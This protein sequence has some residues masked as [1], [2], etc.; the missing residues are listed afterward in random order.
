MASKKMIALAVTSSL[1]SAIAA[2]VPF[3][4]AAGTPVITLDNVDANPGTQV[5]V[6]VYLEENEGING[7]SFSVMY[8][9]SA[10]TLLEVNEGDYPVTNIPMED[11]SF[12]FGHYSESA[13]TEEEVLL[14]EMVFDVNENAE[15]G[16]YFL[17]INYSDVIIDDVSVGAD[18]NS[19]SINV[20]DEDLA[21][22]INGLYTPS[23][24]VIAGKIYA[25]PGSTA[26]VPLTVKNNSGFDALK[27][28]VNYDSSVFSYKNAQSELVSP[29]VTAGDNSLTCTIDG[30]AI[31]ESDV[32]YYLAFDVSSTAETGDYPFS[33]TVEEMKLG[34]ADVEYNRVNGKVT[35]VND[36]ISNS[37]GDGL[38]NGQLYYDVYSDHIVITGYETTY[39]DE[40]VEVTDIIIPS[41]IEGLPVTEIG[42]WAFSYADELTSVT[43]PETITTVGDGAFLLCSGLTSLNIP[44]SVVTIGDDAFNMCTGIA[45]FEIPAKTASIGVNAFLDCNALSIDNSNIS[46][47]IDNGILMNSAKTHLLQ[48]TDKSAVSYEV[49]STVSEIDMYAFYNMTGLTKVVLPEGLTA[50]N[51]GT[52]YGCNALVEVN[53]PESVTTIGDEAFTAVSMSEIDIPAS[54]NSIGLNAFSSCDKLMSINVA[55]SNSTYSDQNGILFDKTGT[56]LVKAPTLKELGEYVVPDTVDIIAESAF[57]YNATLTSITIPEGVSDIGACAFE[58]CTNLETVK[59]MGMDTI[60]TGEEYTVCNGADDEGTAIFNG[61]LYGYTGSDAQ[62][63]A[64]E[65]NYQFE[66]ISPVTELLGDANGDGSVNSTDIVLVSRYIL[67]QRD[68]LVFNN[69]DILNDEVIDSFDMVMLRKELCN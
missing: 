52:F 31:N 8:D 36:A 60:F 62:E 54:V 41:E 58:E 14:C 3:A 56:T 21:G 28:T 2:T 50:I 4:E 61:V 65:Y 67:S 13:I 48:F 64:Q 26:L 35:L 32:L 57:D 1:L 24:T 6:P 51:E 9:T 25:N 22:I 20:T 12:I 30:T 55:D 42:E 49:P 39:T 10:L 7:Y 29:E 53:I 23:P 40:D 44:E 46:Y 38:Y 33:L 37:E 63:Y 68:N 45:E 69:S 43:L 59:V 18:I 34:G 19:G 16:E 17:N 66:L 47:I 27:V 11:D 15:L 5:T